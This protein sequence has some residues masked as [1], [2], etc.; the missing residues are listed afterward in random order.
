MAMREFS[1]EGAAR[2]K[3][4]FVGSLPEAEDLERFKER[5]FLCE[6]CTPEELRRP[7]YA[8]Q[9]DAVIWTQDPVKLNTLP[10]ELGTTV[11]NLL[12]HDVRVYVR[13]ATDQKLS[14]TPRKLVVNALLE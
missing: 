10:R 6:S 3:I 2:A 8:A 14:E 5:N 4:A 7:G 13:L 12:D 9:L 11:P 1:S